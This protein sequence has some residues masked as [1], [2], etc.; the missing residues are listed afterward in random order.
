L[1]SESLIL[2]APQALSAELLCGGFQVAGTHGAVEQ[3]HDTVLAL[4]P[5]RSLFSQLLLD[6]PQ[7]RIREVAQ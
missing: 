5:C 1:T 3:P 7:F 4:A 2:G 6:L